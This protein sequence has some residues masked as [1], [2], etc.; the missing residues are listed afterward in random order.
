MKANKQ[1]KQY[2]GLLRIS[3]LV[4]KP[5]RYTQKYGTYV[6]FSSNKYVLWDICIYSPK[7]GNALTQKQNVQYLILGIPALKR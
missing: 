6:F 1:T 3:Q 2:K 5:L 4:L 7:R